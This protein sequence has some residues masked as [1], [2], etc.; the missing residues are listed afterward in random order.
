MTNRIRNAAAALFLISDASLLLARLLICPADRQTSS[1]QVFSEHDR[2]TCAAAHRTDFRRSRRLSTSDRRSLLASPHLAKG[3]SRSQAFTRRSDVSGAAGKESR[4]LS[5]QLSSAG[6]LLATSRL[7]LSNCKQRWSAWPGTP[8]SP[9]C[10]A[11]SLTHWATTLVIAECLA[12][13]ALS[14]RL[15][16]NFYAHDQ[17]F[18]GEL[19]QRAE[20]ELRTHHTVRQ[21]K[22]T[23][24]NY[25]EIELVRSDSAARAKTNRDAEHRREDEQQRVGR[26]RAKTGSNV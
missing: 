23:S 11:N 14:E 15:V 5:A 7:L 21:M 22:Q 8:S 26:K 12:R 6:G 25:S 24:G 2:E 3:A 19:K 1:P 10:C 17:R 13:P 9:R 16:T 20:A 18:H 4:R